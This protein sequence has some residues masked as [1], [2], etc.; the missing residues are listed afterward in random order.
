MQR[1]RP[2]ISVHPSDTF[3]DI[4]F[5]RMHLVNFFSP[6]IVGASSSFF[7]PDI[8]YN[9]PQGTFSARALNTRVEKVDFQPKALFVSE[10][11]EKPM[12]IWI[13]NF[14]V[15]CSLG[16]V[17]AREIFYRRTVADSLIFMSLHMNIILDRLCCSS[18][19]PWISISTFGYPFIA[20]YIKVFKILFRLRLP[21]ASWVG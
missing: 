15:T 21:L 1:V 19:D 11:R 17:A 9:I 5:K 2:T 16:I 14:T 10:T 18:V 6:S 13:N 7:E 4:V 20:G 3:C 12:V 8:D